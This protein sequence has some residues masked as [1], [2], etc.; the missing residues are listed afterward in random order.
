MNILTLL[1]IIPVLTIVGILFTK[2]FKGARMVSAVGMGMQLLT[3]AILLLTYLGARNSGAT[4]E[5]LFMSDYTWFKSLNIHYTIGVDGIA[6]AMICLTSVVVFAGIFASWEVEFLSREFFISLILLATGVFG[7]FIS[8][9]LFTMFLFYEVAVIPMY[10]L[11]GIWGSGPKEKSAMKLTLMLM[12]GSALLMVGIFGIYFNSAPNGGPLTFN[13]LEIAK[14]TI[15][16]GAQRFFF[17]FTFVGFGILG[18]L[19]PFH[20]WSP[21][22]HASAPT[23]V[24]MLHAGVL[25][26]LGG[27]GCFRVAM[28]LMPE[29]ANEMAWIFI[30]LTSISVVYGAFGAIWQ[31]D[32]KYINAY[33]SV[34]HC[35][36][37]IFA[38]LMMNQTAMDGAIIQMISHGLMTALFFALIGM[39]YGRTHTRNIY[40][41]GGLMKVIPFLGVVYMIAGFAS[42]GLPGL[43]GFV[44][45]MTVFVGAF[46]H[47]DIFHRVATIL[48]ASS[49]VITAV[50]ILRVVGVLLLGPIKDPHHEHLTDARWFERL[51]TLTLVV[52]VAAIGIAP[53][54]LSNTI[55]ES[56]RPVV[57]RLATV[58]PF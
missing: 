36:L 40:E 1:I 28:F 2:D 12:G 33:S 22:G 29:A 49:I 5:M 16:V 21:D 39:I 57:A 6:V 46:Q 48:A 52:A 9:D 32:L 19:F 8:L 35:G 4:A 42:L 43:S 34:S 14:I 3:S 54:W 31:K 18:A 53:L 51:S 11:I 24:S 37:V 20:T 50:Y 56:L 41:M 15:P 7:F 13:I 47:Q 26:K 10:L 44:A 38:L 30:I 27:Y 25:M 58:I 55:L 17:P 23:A 45:E